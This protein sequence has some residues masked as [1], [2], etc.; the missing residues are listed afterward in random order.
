MTFGCNDY[1]SKNSD[2]VCHRAEMQ[3]FEMREIA[4]QIFEES[5][6]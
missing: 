2:S 5:Q 4:A 6:V 3:H 1:G